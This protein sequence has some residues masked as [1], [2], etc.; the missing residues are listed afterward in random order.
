MR[1]ALLLP[2]LIALACGSDADDQQAATPAQPGMQSSGGQSAPPEGTGGASGS[3]APPPPHD[4]GA[5]ELQ[6]AGTTHAQD[7]S[8]QPARDAGSNAARADVPVPP[9]VASGCVDDVN[10]GLHSFS[11]DGLTF[12]TN[13][14]ERCIATQCG[15]V[16]DVHGGTMSAEMEDKNTE[17]RA[18]GAERG[19]VVIQPNAN[20]GL[21][22]AANDDP[23]VFAFANSVID[24]FHL[25]PDRVHMMGFSQGG[26]MTWRFACA[27][28]D[29]LASAAPAAAAGEANIS[30]E[31]GCTFTGQDR[32]HGEL[33]I[34][35]MHGHRD[36]LVDFANAEVLR[37][38]VIAAYAA[39]QHELIDSGDAFMR[40]RYTNAAGTRFEFLEHDYATDSAVGEPPLGVAIVGHCYP[41]ST[42]LEITLPD[43]L[44]SFGCTPPT[45]FTWAEEALRFF[46]DHPRR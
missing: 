20:L 11:C 5:N 8:A 37:D 30:A 16:I 36:G 19:Y 1:V 15:L 3:S 6:D 18:R 40:T 7:A 9:P 13:V 24:V 45:G 27:H 26:Y 35:Y 42:D 28:T 34:L 4:A 2:L 31:V 29:W 10:A 12:M 32:P 21:F 17:M 46:E 33:D 39:D 41:G 43:Q 23:I 14:P 44:M 22:D 25:D 38:A